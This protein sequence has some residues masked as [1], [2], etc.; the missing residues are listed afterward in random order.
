MYRHLCS[1]SFLITPFPAPVSFTVLNV[2][3]KSLSNHNTK[4]RFNDSDFG[5]WFW[6]VMGFIVTFCLLGLQKASQAVH[7]L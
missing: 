2:F 7:F 5:L 4:Q 1:V 6:E 3:E